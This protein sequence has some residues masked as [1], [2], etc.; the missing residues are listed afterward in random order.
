MRALAVAVACAGIAATP[1]ALAAE[2]AV[3]ALSSLKPGAAF[4]AQFHVITIPKTAH[5]RIA[6]VDDQGKTVLKIDSDNSTG[7]LAMPFLLDPAA[8]PRL[9]WRWKVS[10]ALD[11]AD[12]ETKAGD[13]YAARVYVFF[14]VPLASLSFVERTKIRLARLVAGQDVPTAALCYVWDNRHRIGH[15]HMSPYTQ[16]AYMIVLQSGAEYAGRWMTETRDVVAD[17]RQAFGHAPPRIIGVA[18]GSD[19]DNTHEKVTTW[20]GDV[21]FGATPP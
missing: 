11:Q 2:A 1:R 5:S 18:L 9:T 17:F 8:T 3:P 15:A 21:S 16:R 4:P 10:H 19:T 7:S 14:D 6:L 13:D 12:T 20:F